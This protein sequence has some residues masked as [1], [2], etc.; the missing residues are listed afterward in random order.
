[1]PGA[2]RARVVQAKLESSGISAQAAECSLFDLHGE[3][4][5]AALDAMVRGAEPPFVLVDGALACSGGID[6]D[7]VVEAAK[8]ARG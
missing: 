4:R 1:M 2:W 7:A 8:R 3:E 6:L 5:H